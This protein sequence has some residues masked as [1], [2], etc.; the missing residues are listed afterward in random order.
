MTAARIGRALFRHRGWIPVPGLVFMATLARPSAA[1]L[2]LG[3]VLCALG[4]VLR[5]WAVRHLGPGGR[6]RGDEV[7]PLALGGPYRWSRNPCYV[8]NLLLWSG[9]AAAAAAPAGAVVPALLGVHWR[10]V[11]AWE[12]E[13]LTAVHGASYRA[14]ASR[15]P[16]WFAPGPRTPPAPPRVSPM[17]ALRSERS[18]LAAG[19][20]AWALIAARCGM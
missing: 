2:A 12:E 3:A 9:L 7:G 8:G 16:R 6:T 11:V 18:S 20:V 10:L 17:A 19:V 13:R 5:L 14:F 15:V 4:A 1:S